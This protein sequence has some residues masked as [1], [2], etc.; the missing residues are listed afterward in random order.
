MSVISFPRRIDTRR[1]RPATRPRTRPDVTPEARRRPSHVAVA[2]R[3]R[4]VTSTWR[5]A[6]SLRKS[7]IIVIVA[8]A[9]S[10]AGSMVVA[11]RQVQLHS[12]QSQLLQ[13]QSTYAEQVGSLTDMSAPSQIATKAGALHLVDPLTVTQ[14]PSTSLDAPLPLPKFLGYAPATSRT[15]R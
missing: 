14:V 9:L 7:S 3:R 2:P 13:A 8:L 10:M 1:A 5:R 11:N 6:T 12:L 15:I 4:A